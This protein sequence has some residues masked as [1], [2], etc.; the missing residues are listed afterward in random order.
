MR[1]FVIGLLGTL[2]LEPGWN[3]S[4]RHARA[5]EQQRD[6]SVS[7]ERI[8]GQNVQVVPAGK[9]PGLQLT[10][11]PSEWP[12]LAIL[13][14]G[15]AHWDWSWAGF[16]VV[17]LENPGSR[18]LE[19]GIRIDD[20][21]TADG[22]HHCRTATARVEPG[23]TLRRA[24]RI[25]PDPMDQFGMRG[26][27]GPQGLRVLTTGGA[28][29]IQLEHIVAVRV[30]LHGPA[31]PEV[32]LF[33]H[34]TLAEPTRT[35]GLV[36]RFG[37]STLND[38]PGKVHDE[39]D[40]QRQRDTESS[41]LAATSTL[42]GRDR[43]GGWDGGPTLDAT[44]FFRTEKID[45]R[46]WL[47]D[48]DGRLFFSSGIDC[49]NPGEPTLIEGREELFTK[50][51]VPSTGDL[52]HYFGRVANVHRGPSHGGKTFDFRHANLRRKL[53]PEVNVLWREEALKR[54]PS[55]GFNTIGNWSDHS[56]YRNGHVPYVATLSIGGR[57]RRLS[58]GSDYWGKIHD[59]FDA[60]FAHSVDEAIR[61]VAGIRNDPWCLGI[62]VDN[63]LS[64]GGF[65]PKDEKGRVGLALGALQSAADQPARQALLAQ[66]KS[67][68]PKIDDL[69]A[70]WH[71]S[72]ADWAVLEGQPWAPEAPYPE[73]LTA[74]LRGFVRGLADRY[75]TTIRDRLKPL[76]P[77]HLYLG[78]RFAWKTPEAIAA[79]DAACDVV[80]FNIYQRS[81]DPAKWS[82]LGELK[83][84]AIIGEFHVGATDRG[85]F[86]PGLVE[87]AD[88]EERAL[89][90]R[91]FVES[92]LD[93]PTLVGCH[94]F[95]NADQPLA[96]RAFDGENYNIGF[97]T[98][99]DTPYP[100]M[101]RAARAVHR[102]L[103][104][105]RAGSQRK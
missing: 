55:W 38:W 83:R 18:A 53:G 69:N 102:T 5:V 52:D 44:G 28:G 90:F 25:G 32:L 66:L 70:A 60:E 103:Y 48:P 8:E 62:F 92:V 96:G 39:S 15:Q 74:D 59:P 75:F 71:T 29:P 51:P 24:V 56:L 50:L 45:G 101:V 100:E 1:F 93:S 79:A 98:V 27:P 87:A 65:D 94:W 33:R 82:L 61:P 9:G 16:L 58:S 4:T 89:V 78:C 31:Q 97:V 13:P 43:F 104:E 47:V 95:Q 86:H 63:E 37:Q 57:H 77:D 35:R 19:V 42:P 85:M 11:E 88:Q 34:A 6:G 30:F 64:W 22:V 49:V 17:E 10:F 26:L 72:F 20:D 67:K 7:F 40:L 99:T 84:P 73:A 81:V 91:E 105:R 36:D 41:D 2:I 80:S 46:W 21:S 68:Y 12:T 14:K 3:A 54:L 76:D 23:S